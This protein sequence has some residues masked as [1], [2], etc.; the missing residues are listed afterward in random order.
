MPT[1]ELSVL[2]GMEST[3]VTQPLPLPVVGSQQAGP[4]STGGPAQAEALTETSRTRTVPC[5]SVV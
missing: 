4:V 5:R 3:C 1:V 2:K